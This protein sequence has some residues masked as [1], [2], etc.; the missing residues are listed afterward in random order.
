MQQGTENHTVQLNIPVHCVNYA[1]ISLT[2]TQTDQY[3]GR[4]KLGRKANL[5]IMG[6]RRAQS[7]KCQQSLNK[8]DV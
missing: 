8:Q 7:R 2:K 3:P 5:K 4:I 6:R 1:L